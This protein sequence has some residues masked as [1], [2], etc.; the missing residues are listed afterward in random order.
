MESTRYSHQI[1]IKL[2][3]SWKILKYKISSKSVQWEPSCS[4]RTHKKKQIS[5]FSQLYVPKN[6][7]GYLRNWTYWSP[8]MTRQF[9]GDRWIRRQHCL[10]VSNV[11]TMLFTSGCEVL[12]PSVCISW[13]L[14][15]HLN[16]EVRCPSGRDVG[17][18]RWWRSHVPARAWR[19]VISTRGLV[20]RPANFKSHCLCYVMRVWEI[21]VKEARLTH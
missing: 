6:R 4:M 21:P 16:W 2:N 17:K 3:F 19:D 9:A 12:F 14:Y 10:D 7:N 8:P 5:S 20:W 18:T 1:L 13:M 11:L 15:G